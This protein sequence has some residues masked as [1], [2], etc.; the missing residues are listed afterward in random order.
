M[1]VDPCHKIRFFNNEKNE[2]HEKNSWADNA[3]SQTKPFP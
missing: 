3:L 2:K 1:P